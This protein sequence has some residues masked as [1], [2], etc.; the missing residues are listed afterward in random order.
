VANIFQAFAGRGIYLDN[1]DDAIELDADAFNELLAELVA[2]SDEA[3]RQ[4]IADKLMAMVEG[5][6][7]E[8][9]EASHSSS[10]VRPNSFVDHCK[11]VARRSR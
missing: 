2:E 1:R 5:E 10:G 4:T 11:S 9:V 8:T 7:A 3:A 6:P